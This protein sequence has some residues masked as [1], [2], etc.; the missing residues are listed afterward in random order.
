MAKKR[1]YTADYVLLFLLAAVIAVLLFYM[2]DRYYL[3]DEAVFEPKQ[4]IV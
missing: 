3:N 1:S 4:D 2:L